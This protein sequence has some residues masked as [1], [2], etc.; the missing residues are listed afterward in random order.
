MSISNIHFAALH[1]TSVE[2]AKA[3]QHLRFNVTVR[4]MNMST[5][6][7]MSKEG[8]RTMLNRNPQKRTSQLPTC[9]SADN[10]KM[11]PSL[12]LLSL[13]TA[14][15]ASTTTPQVPGFDISNWQPTFN[16][17]AAYA[18]GARFCIIKA[19]PP[20]PSPNPPHLTPPPSKRPQ[21]AATTSTSP[22]PPT[23]SEPQPPISSAAPTISPGPSPTPRRKPTFSSRTAA[24]GRRMAS[25]SL[26]CW[27]WR[28]L[29]VSR[30]AGGWGRGRWW[31]GLGR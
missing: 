17:T 19:C 15:H 12:T 16:F 18:S 26:G 25:R 22:S 14:A 2:G 6:S 20:P 1:P 23:S 29:R 7:F 24:G 4:R 11:K 10:C 8:Q 30:R 31:R 5:A 21:K 28:A 27:T 3:V 13:L 9:K